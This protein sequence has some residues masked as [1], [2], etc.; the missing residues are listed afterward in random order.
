[1]ERRNIR[2]LFLDS[3]Q[4]GEERYIKRKQSPTEKK[5]QSPGARTR[6]PVVFIFWGSHPPRSPRARA[7]PEPAAMAMHVPQ[8]GFRTM[9]K[10]GT[11]VLFFF[12]FF[13]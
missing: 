2:G 9:M 1:L 10:D 12:V 13:Q 8:T 11:K 3:V 5:N 4:H 7:H 6:S